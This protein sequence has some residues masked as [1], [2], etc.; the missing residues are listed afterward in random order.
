MYTVILAIIQLYS[1]ITN[2]HDELESLLLQKILHLL[3]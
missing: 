3:N 1:M 2:N